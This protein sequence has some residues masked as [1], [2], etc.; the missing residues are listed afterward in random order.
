LVYQSL[1][2]DIVS[3]RKGLEVI[4]ADVSGLLRDD[5]A[6]GRRVRGVMLGSARELCA[7]RVVLCT[8]TFLGGLMHVGDTRVQGG[9]EG[10]AASLGLGAA[11][12]AAGL[13]L[14]RLKTGTPPRL[15]RDT[16]DFERVERQR[17]DDDPAPF[18]FR[19]VDFAPDQVDC[20]VTHTNARTHEII[21]N[22]LARSPLYGGII[23]GTGPRYC[24]SIEDKIVR[25]ADKTRHFVFLEPEGRDNEEVY[26]NGLSTSLPRDVQEDMVHSIVG[27][28]E[29]VLTR[30]GYAVEYDSVPSWQVNASLEAKPVAGLY[31]AG[32]ILGTSGYEEAAAQGLAAGINAVRSLTGKAPVAFPRERSYMGV[33]LDDL[34][35]KEITEPYRMF[36]SRA[37][38]RLYLRCDNVAERML[39]L[40][41]EIGLLETG[42]L[43]HLGARGEAARRTLSFLKT[44]RATDGLTGRRI[45]AAELMKR[46]ENNIQSLMSADSFMRA[47]LDALHASAGYEILL[48]P[49]DLR[50]AET[51]AALDI[52]YAGYISRQD[53]MLRNRKHLDHLQLPPELDYFSL[54]ALSNEAREKLAGMRPSTLGQASR[55]DGVRQSDLA[56]LSVMVM[57]LKKNDD[58]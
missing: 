24:P 45:A 19:T 32:Q 7:D 23:E 5:G 52:R 35:T 50:E 49:A 33:L 43:A 51:Q 20:H 10:A 11:L 48:S 36:T 15:H 31:L 29:A 40:A 46:P 21:R 56:V 26:V 28:E 58:G 22:N 13:E 16:I 8:G 37:E 3:N 14:V 12:T 39:P 42:D 55:I 54:T 38:S 9:R 47:D 18:S 2:C 53:K 41:R 25:F 6:G 44:A 34:V 57:R 30:S 17:G 27:L 1:M 4:E